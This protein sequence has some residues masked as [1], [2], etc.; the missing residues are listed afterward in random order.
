VN[1]VLNLNVS[2]ITFFYGAADFVDPSGNCIAR[3]HCYD[4][5]FPYCEN[6]V[7]LKELTQSE[8]ELLSKLALEDWDAR[9]KKTNKRLNMLRGLVGAMTALDEM[10]AEL[11][12][13]G[14][15]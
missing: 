15:G 7:L 14:L 6:E 9:E 1:D 3:I 5:R 10:E 11:K 4:P 13:A 12:E 2:E 8:I